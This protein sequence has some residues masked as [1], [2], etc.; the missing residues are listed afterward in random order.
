MHFIKEFDPTKL[1]IR[2][3]IIQA[4]FYGGRSLNIQLSYDDEVMSRTTVDL[5]TPNEL[6]IHSDF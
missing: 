3:D 6:T 1:A 2:A 5:P 4:D